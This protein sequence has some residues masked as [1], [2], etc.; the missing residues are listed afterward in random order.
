MI[1]P[2]IPSRWDLTPAEAR[3]VQEELRTRVRTRHLRCRDLTRVAGC[4]VAVAGN[5]LCA[6]AL[7]FS[8]PELVLLETAT[9][10][11]EAR[12]H[13]VPGLL[14]FREIPVLLD[15]LAGLTL[16]P[17]AIL[18]DGQGRAHPRRIGLASHLGVLLD[19]PT[20]GCAKSC[21]IGKYEEPGS[22]KGQRSLLLDGEEIIGTV[23][24]TRSGVQPLF[25][26]VGHRTTLSDAADLV[27]RCGRGL[28]LPE[29]TRMADLV[30]G[31]MARELAGH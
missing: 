21:L 29:P 13:Y 6:A 4:D 12:F 9:A 26:S 31:R 18:C 27:L 23:L 7:V 19:I 15:A 2:V 8:F 25:I 17:D 28:R 5:R 20:V 14:S 22:A 3:Q 16:R 11:G 30:V 1:N 10:V 24:R